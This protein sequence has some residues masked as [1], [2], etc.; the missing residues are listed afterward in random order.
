L[1]Y[2][3]N[4]INKSWSGK[5]IDNPRY[6]F[7]LEKLRVFAKHGSI[8]EGHI[9]VIYLPISKLFFQFPKTNAMLLLLL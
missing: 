6:S 1:I 8:F 2:Q 9:Q 3:R 5:C 4:G 7:P